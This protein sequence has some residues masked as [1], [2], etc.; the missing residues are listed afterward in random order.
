MGQI[1]STWY[2]AFDELLDIEEFNKEGYER[3]MPVDESTIT[4]EEFESIYN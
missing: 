4:E 3:L 1:A 2:K